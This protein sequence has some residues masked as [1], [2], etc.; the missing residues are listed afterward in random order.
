MTQVRKVPP[1]QLNSRPLY[2]PSKMT[3]GETLF[4]IL[5]RANDDPAPRRVI[6]ESKNFFV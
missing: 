2:D 3:Q 4:F 5:G 1:A 6:E